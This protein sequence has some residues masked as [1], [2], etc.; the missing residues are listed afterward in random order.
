MWVAFANVKATHI[1]NKNISI[2]AIFNDQSFNDTLTNDNVSFEQLGPDR[3]E[4]PWNSIV[5]QRKRFEYM[6][7]KLAA[8]GKLVKG[9]LWNYTCHKIKK[10]TLH[11]YRYLHYISHRNYSTDHLR[12]RTALIPS[13]TSLLH[14]HTVTWVLINTVKIRRELSR[15]QIL[16]STIL[17]IW[18]M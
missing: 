9:T 5:S 6:A 16:W 17:L 2:Y 1:F 18:L 8:L 3:G 10:I 4:S 12:G 7:K 11:F 14:Q 13:Y 15:C